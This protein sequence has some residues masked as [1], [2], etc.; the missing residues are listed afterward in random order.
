MKQHSVVT[1]KKQTSVVK[2]D[3]QSKEHTERH[4]A[5]QKKS[6]PGGMLPCRRTCR[7]A[8]CSAEEHASKQAY[9]LD[10]LRNHVPAMPRPMHTHMSCPH[11]SNDIINAHCHTHLNAHILTHPMHTHDMLCHVV[12]FCACMDRDVT[13]QHHPA[14]VNSCR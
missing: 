6:M 8:C 11:P 13:S 10:C 12:S 3:A 9:C 4:V 2:T 14:D 7:A 5:L 1:Q